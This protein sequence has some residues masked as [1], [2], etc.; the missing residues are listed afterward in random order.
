MEADLRRKHPEWTPSES[1]AGDLVLSEVCVV[2]E[3]VLHVALQVAMGIQPAAS[4][5]APPPLSKK[6]SSKVALLDAVPPPLSKKSSSKG[7]LLGALPPSLARQR[8]PMSML[9]SASGRFKRSKTGSS[10]EL[11]GVPRAAP[12]GVT[13]DENTVDKLAS[14]VQKA[15]EVIVTQRLL[16]TDGTSSTASSQAL[17][18]L[19]RGIKQCRQGLSSGG[20]DLLMSASRAV[21][22][23]DL[24]D[25]VDWQKELQASRRERK[26][27]LEWRKAGYHLS[28]RFPDARL[29]ALLGGDSFGGVPDKIGAPKVAQAVE[30][31]SMARMLCVKL[32]NASW[33]DEASWNDVKELLESAIHR[34]GMQA[35]SPEMVAARAELELAQAFFQS[36]PRLLGTLEKVDWA[37][38]LMACRGERRANRVLATRL[39]LTALEAQYEQL[40]QMLPGHRVDDWCNSGILSRVRVVMRLLSGGRACTRRPHNCMRKT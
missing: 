8:S 5:A 34:H 16:Q 38:S 12:S 37:E 13:F 6:S 21:E 17:Q 35:G 40:S 3:E 18:T 10:R 30:R 11:V 22:L 26:G 15:A 1:A 4:G 27:P 14:A 33:S 31:A 24:L 28:E 2:A 25:T 29:E 19:V 39:P 20:S 32:K 36:P 9:L 23:H 7:S